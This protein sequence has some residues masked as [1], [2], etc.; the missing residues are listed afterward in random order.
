MPAIKTYSKGRPFLGGLAQRPCEGILE[1][2]RGRSDEEKH[3]ASK[4]GGDR[5]R[6]SNPE[7][8]KL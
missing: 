8:E 3:F 7:K 5:V 4:N 2:K 6:Q 1:N